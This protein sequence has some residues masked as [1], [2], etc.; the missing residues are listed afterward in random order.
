MNERIEFE[1]KQIV[2]VPFEHYLEKYKNSDAD[3]ISSRTGLAFDKDK[4]AFSIKLMG[5]HYLI[6]HPDFVVQNDAGEILRTPYEEILLIRYLLEG[7]YVPP[8]EKNLSYEEMPWGKVYL[9][10]F[11]GRVI[12]RITYEFGKD[13]SIFSK[14]I[15]NMPGLTYT[16]VEK[17]DTGYRFE[18]IDNLFITIMFWAGDD[19][20]PTSAQFLFSDNFKFAFTAEDIAVVG[21]TVIGRLKAMKR[22]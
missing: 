21:D 13:L 19:E 9:T 5:T 3:E 17:C 18:F 7:A 8:G 4:S 15:E 6:S 11:K 14:T 22:V 20:F 16:Q 12:G 2:K 1:D 10:N